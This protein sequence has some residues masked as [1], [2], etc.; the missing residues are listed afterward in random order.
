MNRFKELVGAEVV[1]VIQLPN[2]EKT[3]IFKCD[4]GVTG[5]V[6]LKI[7][8]KKPVVVSLCDDGSKEFYMMHNEPEEVKDLASF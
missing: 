3:I 7:N 2:K 5:M 6:S 4:S 8:L 1:K